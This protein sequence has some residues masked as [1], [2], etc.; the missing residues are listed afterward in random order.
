MPSARDQNPYQ[1]PQTP[2][3]RVEAPDDSSPG[4]ENAPPRRW[5]SLTLVEILVVIAIIGLLLALLLPAV[6]SSPRRRS[7]HPDNVAPAETPAPARDESSVT[8]KN[9]GSE[10]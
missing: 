5:Y 6:Q 9:P 7:R 2:H 4:T 1:P 8:T 3:E 10:T